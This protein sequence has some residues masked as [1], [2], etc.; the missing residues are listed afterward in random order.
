MSIKINLN[1]NCNEPVVT[2][3]VGQQYSNV[4]INLNNNNDI[5]QQQAISTPPAIPTPEEKTPI[6]VEKVNTQAPIE[7]NTQ[8]PIEANTQAPIE[9]NT[10]APIEANT[11]APQEVNTQAPI[12]VNT[13]APQEVNTQ[14]PIEVNTQAPQEVN[15]PKEE[16]TIKKKCE[17]IEQQ[18]SILLFNRNRKD[19]NYS[20]EEKQKIDQQIKLLNEKLIQLQKTTN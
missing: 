20:E 1:F 12:E 9:A 13:Q 11:Q 18:I 10:Q 6:E 8:A 7:A 2:I 15:T 5:I 19:Y 3:N 14:A 17:L 16:T 4:T